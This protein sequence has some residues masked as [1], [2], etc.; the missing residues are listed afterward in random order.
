MA[1]RIATV[2]RRVTNCES[3][4][5]FPIGIWGIPSKIPNHV[6]KKGGKVPLG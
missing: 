5:K 4:P 6:E 2:E 1:E 3:L